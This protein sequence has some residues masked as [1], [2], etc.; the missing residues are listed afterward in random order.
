MAGYSMV[1]LIKKKADMTQEEFASYWINE[2]TPLTAQ[3]EGVRAYRCFPFHAGQNGPFDAIAFITF[4][5][6]DSADRALASPAFER[7]LDDAANFQA[8]E[9]TLSFTADEHVIV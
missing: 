5:D 2:H 7:A 6:R 4:D 1:F 3:V 9:Q 8:V